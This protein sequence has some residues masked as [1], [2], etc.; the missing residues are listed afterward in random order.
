MEI[1]L[2]GRNDRYRELLLSYLDLSDWIHVAETI[3]QAD[4]SV[5]IIESRQV[6]VVL[7]DS[8][9]NLDESFRVLG[10]LKALNRPIP[11]LMV[12]SLH[13]DGPLSAE[14]RKLGADVIIGKENG[15]WSLIFSLQNE[16]CNRK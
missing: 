8:V 16:S 6:D 12:I 7:I 4:K 9:G 15:I 5:A 13:S 10:L 2:L 3:S 11:K 1:L 14:F